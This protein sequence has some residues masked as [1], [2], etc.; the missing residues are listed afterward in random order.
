[1]ARIGKSRGSSLSAVAALVQRHDRDR[2]LTTLFAPAQV[3]EDL[4]AL[5]A[6]NYELAKIRETVHEPMM[7]R[8]RLQW[9]RDAVAE[10]AAG[11][12]PRQ[13]EVAEPLARTIRAHRLS[14]AVLG[15][16]IDAREQDLL[17]DPPA[18]MA[19]L[20]DYA[21]A[22]GGGLN[23]L[24]LEILS[25]ADP[26]GSAATAARHV[27]VA[28]ALV[29]LLR[30]TTYYARFG[31]SFIPAR[32]DPGRHALGTKASRALRDAAATIADVAHTRLDKARLLVEEAPVAAAMPALLLAVV[33]ARWL[34]R[35]ESAGYDL[36]SPRIMRPDPWRGARLFWAAHRGRI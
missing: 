36:F 17:S 29:G 34:T 14:Q 33:V 3:R 30:A 12:A 24:A 22:T 19:E 5:Y 27:G 35:I 31:R 8:I 23:L 28:Y 10:I 26:N 18:T 2:F 6:F 15:R 20:E 25:V 4:L 11:Q 9:W 21:D 13:H 16:M 32:L 1:M 7:G